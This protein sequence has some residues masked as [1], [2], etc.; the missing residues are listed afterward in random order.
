MTLEE[1]GQ[2]V[3]E[4][5]CHGQDSDL[6]DVGRD[7]VKFYKVGKPFCQTYLGQKSGLCIRLTQFDLD[8]NVHIEDHTLCQNFT[9]AKLYWLMC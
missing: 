2:E 1:G 8:L 7:K 9:F 3:V 4:V 6:K 5:K